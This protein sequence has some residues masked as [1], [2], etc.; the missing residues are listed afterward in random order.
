[1]NKQSTAYLGL[2]FYDNIAQG[3]FMGDDNPLGLE[4]LSDIVAWREEFDGLAEHIKSALDVFDVKERVEKHESI[5][6][7]KQ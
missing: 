3:I 4:I 1:M 5:N 2:F 6:T 7:T